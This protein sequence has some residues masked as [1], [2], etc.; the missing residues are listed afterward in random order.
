M[1]IVAT[2][3]VEKQF[4]FPKE[5]NWYIHNNY[6]FLFIYLFGAPHLALL[7]CI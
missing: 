6:M 4:P 5:L 2:A 3:Q 1:V 7:V